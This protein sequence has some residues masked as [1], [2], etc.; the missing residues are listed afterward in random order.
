MELRLL[1]GNLL[2]TQCDVLAVTCFGDPAK[3]A[4]V[5][6]INAALGG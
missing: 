1:A 5:K 4:T 3:D 6:A 2:E